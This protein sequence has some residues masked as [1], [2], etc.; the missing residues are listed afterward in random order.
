L[1]AQGL[2]N[3]LIQHSYGNA[4]TVDLWDALSKISGNPNIAKMMD[5]W[6]RQAGYPM[7]SFDT[8]GSTTSI[9]ISQQQFLL[10]SENTTNA[11]WIVPITVATETGATSELLLLEGQVTILLSLG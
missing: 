3:Y 1:F 9:Q 6:T 4:R 11:Q 8:Q 2:T 5:T 7:V 10:N